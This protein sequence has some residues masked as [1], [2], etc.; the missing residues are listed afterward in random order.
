MSAGFI[1]RC[2]EAGSRNTGKTGTNCCYQSR[3]SCKGE[4]TSQDDPEKKQQEEAV[5][6]RFLSVW[7]LST[8]PYWQILTGT[9]WP[10]R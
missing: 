10:R 3:L 7:C 6:L 1:E 4:E 9:S 2:D 5:P 8:A